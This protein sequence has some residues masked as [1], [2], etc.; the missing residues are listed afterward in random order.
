M[1][2]IHSCTSG[3]K[4]MTILK[5]FALY[6]R[7]SSIQ[8]IHTQQDGITTST[9]KKLKVLHKLH[10]KRSGRK[11]L[12]K[13]HYWLK[14]DKKYLF[15]FS[16]L[17]TFW[18]FTVEHV[19]FF[20]WKVTLYCQCCNTIYLNIVGTMFIIPIAGVDIFFKIFPCKWHPWHTILHNHPQKHK[21]LSR[22]E[23]CTCTLWQLHCEA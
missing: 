2:S 17:E 5:F 10:Q 1:Y 7:S 13:V 21:L 23:K 15:L 20:G 6:V 11:F 4:D 3:T 8:N 18:I 22:A 14:A 12:H 19:F 9:E 16:P